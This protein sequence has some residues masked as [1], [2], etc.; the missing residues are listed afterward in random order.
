[1]PHWGTK[2]FFLPTSLASIRISDIFH[3]LKIKYRS[4]FH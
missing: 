3:L 4:L 1:M 2:D